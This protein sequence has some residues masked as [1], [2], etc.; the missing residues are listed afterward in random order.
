M[1]DAVR[2]RGVLGH[3]AGTGAYPEAITGA[4]ETMLRKKI[5]RRE[6]VRCILT[7]GDAKLGQADEQ[8]GRK[9]RQSQ[10]RHDYIKVWTLF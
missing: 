4:D 6:K 5:R 10:E 1:A 3:V 7:A 8:E 2:T 9:H